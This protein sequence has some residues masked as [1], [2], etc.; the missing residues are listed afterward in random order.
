MF[1]KITPPKNQRSFRDL[2]QGSILGNLWFLSWPMLVSNTI[3]T[4]GPAIDMVW[5]GRLGTSAIAGV[6]VSGIAVTMVNSLLN[7]L[8]TGAIAILTRAI[9][10]KDTKPVNRIA[11]QA[12]IMAG[13]FSLIMAIIG[14][15]LA[16]PILSVLGVSATAVDEG[17][18]YMKIQFVGMITMAMLQV[19]QS[20]MQSFGDSI[21]PMKISIGFRILQMV[22]C[23]AMVFGF[24]FIPKMGVSGAALSNVIAQAIGAIIGLWIMFFSQRSRFGVSF[25]DFA[26]DWPIIWRAI[27]IGIPASLTQVSRS[28]ADL[29]FVKLMVPFGTIAVAAH[30]LSQRIDSFIQMPGGG[31]GQGAAILVGQNLG[32]K[33]PGRAERTAWIASGVATI[34]S[35]ICSIV[36]WFW[37]ENL[38]GLFN[39]DPELVSM[40]SSFL[41]IQIAAYLVWGVV[42]SLSLCLNGAGDTLIPMITNLIS[43]FGVQIGLGYIL[44]KYTDMGV[45]GLRWGISLGVIARLIIYV[46]Y[47]RTGRWKYKKV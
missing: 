44:S 20:I 21:T 7:G 23:P 2:T 32:A 27:R 15:F 38:T 13:G 25:H 17:T 26:F 46:A 43:M 1:Q 11:Q 18:T 30:S 40:A 10:A 3:N 35:V 28:F 8:F 6:G 36:I 16:R 19:A 34:I 5:V 37:A 22:L 29:I 41:R 14:I 39:N 4:L 45:N 42:V 33:Q 31:F 47:F 24:W 12:F 9:G